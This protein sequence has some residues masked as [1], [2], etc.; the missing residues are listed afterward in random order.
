MD[1]FNVFVSIICYKYTA[2]TANCTNLIYVIIRGGG[3][4]LDYF[5]LS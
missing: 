5:T 2:S 1:S 3:L 4:V